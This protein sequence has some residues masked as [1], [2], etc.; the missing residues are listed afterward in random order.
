MGYW[1]LFNTGFTFHIV[2]IFDEIGVDAN[3]AVRIFFPISIVSVIAR[4]LGSYLSDRIAIHHIYRGFVLML[5]IASASVSVMPRYCP[6]HCDSSLW[7][8]FGSVRHAQYVTWPKLY[9]RK[10]IGAI[11]GF[12]MSMIVAGSAIGPWLFSLSHRF[13][14]S[15]KSVGIF[16]MICSALFLVAILLVKFPSQQYEAIGT[17]E[18]FVPPMKVV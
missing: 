3:Q 11:S 10:H 4:F 13:T 6:D 5:I 18:T 12:A 2:S 1:G 7:C 14:G 8:G 16:G 9:G 17:Q 15:Y